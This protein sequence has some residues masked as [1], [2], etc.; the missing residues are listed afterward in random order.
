MTMS[1]PEN[2][3]NSE[4]ASAML[5]LLGE[6]TIK[7]AV[8]GMTDSLDMKKRGNKNKPGRKYTYSDL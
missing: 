4:D 8:N 6:G 3:Y 1:T 7:T 2:M 5:T